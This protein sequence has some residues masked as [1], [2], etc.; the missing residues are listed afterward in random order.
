MPNHPICDGARALGPC[1]LNA[2]YYVRGARSDLAAC[3]VHLAQIVKRLTEN[4]TVDVWR[5]DPGMPGP[6]DYHPS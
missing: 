4:G 3:G 6:K 2:K 1:D 5:L